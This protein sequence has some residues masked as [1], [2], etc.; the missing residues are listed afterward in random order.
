MEPD[1]DQARRGD[2]V[3]Q[4]AQRRLVG[5]AQQGQGG[6]DQIGVGDREVECRVRRLAGLRAGW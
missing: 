4:P 3:A 1:A 6:D 2:L 5:Q